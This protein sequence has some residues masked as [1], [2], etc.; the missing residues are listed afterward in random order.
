MEAQATL[1][2]SF[3]KTMKAFA[4]SRYKITRNCNENC[5]MSEISVSDIFDCTCIEYS[6]LT[7]VV[8]NLL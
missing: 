5:W 1:N 8:S 7:A 4:H 3:T 2:Y 6:S